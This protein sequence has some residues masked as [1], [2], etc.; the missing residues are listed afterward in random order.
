MKY[1]FNNGVIET[2]QE[3][4]PDGFIHGRLPFKNYNH[5]INTFA[6]K[7]Q[8]QMQE[9]G[10][11]ISSSMTGRVWYTNGVD[12][13]HLLQGEDVPDGYWMGFTLTKTTKYINT[14]KK[15]GH[16]NKGERIDG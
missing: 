11:K 15:K 7:T 12:N 14:R 8:E 16:N 4:C 13:K 5:S 6:N 9:I 3:T 1:W 10:R 2:L